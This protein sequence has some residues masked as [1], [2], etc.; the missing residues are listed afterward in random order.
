M[1]STF[2]LQKPILH[3]LATIH[4]AEDDRQSNQNRP[5][6][7]YHRRPNKIQSNLK[8][9]S[10]SM[11]RRKRRLLEWRLSSHSGLTGCWAE[12]NVA[13][14]LSVLS[15]PYLRCAF[16]VFKILLAIERFDCFFCGTYILLSK[17]WTTC[18]R[19]LLKC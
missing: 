18:V 4:N 8:N 13:W 5:P 11:R 9:C 14:A 16:I 10:K 2:G 6:M 1:P 12:L 15:Q 3:R 7:L 17:P 19:I